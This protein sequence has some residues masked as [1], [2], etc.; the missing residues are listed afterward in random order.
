M[1]VTLE[2][3]VFKFKSNPLQTFKMKWLKIA[4]LERIY[5]LQ[6]FLLL[7]PIS[8]RSQIYRTL[9]WQVK[10]FHPETVS[11]ENKVTQSSLFEPLGLP[12]TQFEK[13][14]DCPEFQ[15]NSPSSFL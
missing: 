12:L 2:S 11:F 14:K 8:S 7:L 6:S 13:V 5:I 3:T 1:H 4:P 10:S 9:D 15:I